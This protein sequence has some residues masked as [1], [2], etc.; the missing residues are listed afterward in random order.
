MR[1]LL[2]II[3]RPRIRLKEQS[4]YKLEEKEKRHIV[5]S[6][7]P[8]LFIQININSINLCVS[9]LYLFNI[10]ELMLFLV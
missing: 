1:L 10:K 5:K 6:G 2:L 8:K 3:C 7:T 4:I 9:L